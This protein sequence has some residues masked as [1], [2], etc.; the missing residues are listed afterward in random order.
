MN[1]NRSVLGGLVAS[2]V[3]PATAAFATLYTCHRLRDQAC[4]VDF[5]I[6]CTHSDGGGPPFITDWFCWHDSDA[7]GWT[8]QAAYQVDAGRFLQPIYV[9]PHGSCWFVPSSCGLTPN[10]C[11][12]GPPYQAKCSDSVISGICPPPP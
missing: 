3:I 5:P 11:I 12:E 6:K 7:V 2:I 10:L 9:P 4:C 8:V 1:W